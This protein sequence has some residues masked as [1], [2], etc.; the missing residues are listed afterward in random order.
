MNAAQRRTGRAKGDHAQFREPFASPAERRAAGKAL[1]DKVPRESHAGFKPAPNRPDPIAT[2][3]AS[4]EG[5]L[6]ELVPI[7]HGRM[8]TSPFAYLRGAAAAMAWD[9]AH[10]PSTGLRVQACGDCHLLNFGVFAS[11]ERELIFDIND[12]DETLPA[13]WE[14]DLKR[15][16]ASIFV[17]GQ[18][19][20]LPK[21][22]CSRAARAA[23]RAYRQR[24]S[25]YA[26]M[27]VLQVWYEHID[28]AMLIREMR[29]PVWAKRL[30]ARIAR[31]HQRTIADHA[32][33]RMTDEGGSRPRIK[34]DPPL[35]FHHA[36]QRR[37]DFG[38]RMAQ[39][40]GS[41]RASLA[42]HFRVLFDRYRLRDIAMKVVGVGSVGTFCAVA[43]YMASDEDPLFLQIKEARASVLEPYAGPSVYAHHGQRVVV[44]Q[45]L[46][47]S[48]S[49]IMLGWTN[50][51][52]RDRH[53][54]VRQLRDMKLPV[55]IEAMDRDT[56]RYYADACGW[57]LARAHARSGDPAA[58][59][60]Y[61]GAGDA[62]IDAILEFATDYAEQTE[63]D[64]K[65]LIRAV[66]DGRIEATAS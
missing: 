21:A 39:T 63:R 55:V 52:K 19:I 42:D 9:L 33:P 56:L 22:D 53:F 54:Y 66:R 49:D 43:L 16:V 15:L 28:I 14:W 36:L 24:M 35:I 2:L 1:R 3:I 12:F 27:P 10:A 11:P 32:Q 37:R 61:L 8:L 51:K 46:M 25:E 50:G 62:F 44:G 45:R 64:Y 30:K 26:A 57:T 31:E 5:R 13:P 17:A 4:D 60:G 47:Q 23:L 58:I 7:R 40:L 34:D 38:D 29:N 20:R 48:A 65:A 59:A 18:H 41:Y 6:P